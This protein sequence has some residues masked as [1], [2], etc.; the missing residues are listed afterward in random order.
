MS[1]A[2]TKRMVRVY[3]KLTPPLTPFFSGMF[4]SPQENFHNSESVELDIMRTNEDVA[5][6]I[7]DLSTGYRYNSDDIYTNKEIKSPVYK[8]A[9]ALNSSDLVKR[10]PGQNPFQDV[11]FRFNVIERMFRGMVKIERKIRRAMELQAAQVL[12]TGQVVLSDLDGLPIFNLDYNP[13]ASHFPTAGASW[14]SATGEQMIADITALA[15]VIRNAGYRP[16]EL[17]FGE[18]ALA[19]FLGKEEVQKMYDIRRMDLGTISGAEQRGNGGTYHGTIQLGAYRF[20]LWSYGATYRDPQTGEMRMYMEPG[21]VLIRDPNA[22][23]DAMFGSI[24]NIGRLLGGG[25]M[26]NLLPELPGRLGGSE[27][28]LDLHTNVWLTP[29]GEQL[30]GGVGAR[31]LM[32]PTA[33]ESFGA[34]DTQL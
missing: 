4:V 25:S 23:L 11:N 22:R 2:I 26:A 8:E 13:E 33:L 15:Q 32:V 20:D 9:I 16:S 19:Q 6:A 34:L 7:H 21:K 17:V 24:P 30:F 14:A 1:T 10:M 28:G 27:R 29:D 5:I 3:D 31:P 12:Q 18:A